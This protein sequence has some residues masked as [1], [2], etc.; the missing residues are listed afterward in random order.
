MESSTTAAVPQQQQQPAPIQAPPPLTKSSDGAQVLQALLNQLAK[1]GFLC[2]L[3]A[4][5]LSSLLV[6]SAYWLFVQVSD[7]AKDQAKPRHTK[8][9]DSAPSNFAFPVGPPSGNKA[10]GKW[11]EQVNSPM[12]VQAWET[13]SGSIVQEF[14]YDLWWGHITPD[15][16]FPKD[17]RRVLNSAFGELAVRAQH[18]DLKRM[19]LTDVSQL[20][21]EQIELYRMTK[22][23]ILQGLSEEAFT[24]MTPQARERA[25]LQEMKSDHNLHPALYP[26]D[27]GPFTGHYKVLRHMCEGLVALL[28]DR[29]DYHKFMMRSVARDLLASLVFRPIMQHMTPYNINKAATASGVRSNKK[30][31][32]QR[33]GSASDREGPV[34]RQAAEALDSSASLKRTGSM[35]RTRSANSLNTA[36]S[37]TPPQQPGAAHQA[38]PAQQRPSQQRPEVQGSAS[39]GSDGEGRHQQPSATLNRQGSKGLPTSNVQ[40]PGHTR[41]GSVGEDSARDYVM[42]RGRQNGGPYDNQ[43]TP[44]ASSSQGPLPQGR[45]QAKVVAADSI[46]ASDTLKEVVV[47]KIRA[48]DANGEWTV[49]R[50]YSNFEQLHR[51]LRD[52]PAYR[53][54]LPPKRLF[55]H[56]PTPDF[57]EERRQQLDTYLQML[58]QE[59]LLQ[60]TNEVAEFLRGCSDLYDVESETGFFKSLGNSVATAKQNMERVVGDMVDDM[61]M[62]RK[63]SLALVTGRT[64]NET[65]LGPTRRPLQAQ[66]SR[67]SRDDPMRSAFEPP[68]QALPPQALRQ[69][70]SSHGRLPG[71]HNVVM[72]TAQ[73]LFTKG[74]KNLNSVKYALQGKEE[75]QLVAR[76]HSDPSLERRKAA[77]SAA[78]TPANS[79]QSTPAS[80][81]KYPLA[82]PF[83][84]AAS[85]QGHLRRQDSGKPSRFQRDAPTGTGLDSPRAAERSAGSA[86]DAGHLD[87]GTLR[88]NS[89]TTPQPATHPAS[90]PRRATL[91][92][93][94]N[95]F[96]RAAEGE[97]AQSSG[98]DA[99]ENMGIS[100][101]LYQII[102][103]VFDLRA[104]GFLRRQAFGVA[105]QML[106][107]VAGSAIDEYLLSQMRLLRQPHTMARIIHALQTKLWP[108]GVWF[109]HTDHYHQ[110]HPP[111]SP[112]RRRPHLTAEHYT[113]VDSAP[114]LDEDEIQ[115]AVYS[116]LVNKAPPVLVRL[117]GR[118]CYKHGVDDLFEMIQSRTFIY[119]L[120]YGIIKIFVV[121]IFPELRP[122]FRQ[123]ELCVGHDPT[124]EGH[125][126]QRRKSTNA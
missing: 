68:T 78:T 89:S 7:R 121:N 88:A 6:A 86:V 76:E 74:F 90:G 18:A 10:E 29:V 51:Q 122:L 44:G 60:G 52:V 48:A 58:L 46:R 70:F 101:P 25:L 95:P 120:G 57:V 113:D 3:I 49:S 63:K 114:P 71:P 32:H 30:G 79:L 22:Q 21:Q 39:E 12:V 109:Q 5:A 99:E 35:P 40:R 15:T 126:R 119:Q 55:V 34:H 111:G 104:R 13:L 59:R 93:H 24:Q 1:V 106:S 20:L 82:T 54:K 17:V 26:H 94:P 92:P 118:D 73:N 37:L 4:W 105:R 47:Y 110:Q 80:T 124:G 33:H 112:N 36:G 16:D 115:E 98:L 9:V 65:D 11:K 28:M 87:M 102:D 116:L 53:L 56:N 38:P 61:D 77:Y 83:D 96:V 100:S 43:G 91:E 45:L 84:G 117:I 97:G 85:E 2:W 69:A 64:D 8:T 107:L 125:M 81:P 50:R 14:L 123:M 103:V 66:R 27:K 67:S 23:N 108:G 75:P 72:D 19:L 31:Q 41:T 62:K 42:G